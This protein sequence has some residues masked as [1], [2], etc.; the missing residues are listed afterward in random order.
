VLC[1]KKQLAAFIVIICVIFSFY[2]C[3]TAS[4]SS[5][6]SAVSSSLPEKP[7]KA[8]HRFVFMAD[9]RGENDGI[10]KTVLDKI[11]KQIKALSPQPEYILV[12]GDLITGSKDTDT[13]KKQLTAFKSFF[14]SYYPINMLLPAYGNHEDSGSTKEVSHEEIFGEFFNEF[15]PTNALQ[16]YHNTAYYVEKDNIRFFVLNS[17][18]EGQTSR[19]IDEQYDWLKQNLKKGDNKLDIAVLHSPPYPTGGHVGSSLDMYPEKR[20]AFWQLLDNQNALAVF[21]G[22]EHNYTRRIVDS[23]FS[24]LFTR[25]LNQITAGSAGATPIDT[26][27]SPLG[28]I[29]P[30]KPVYHFSVIDVTPDNTTIKTITVDGETL[31][32]F[33]LDNI[34]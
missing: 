31:D 29:V 22:H 7:I 16:G 30:P 8:N 28:V 34:Y 15:A 11:F 13:Y 5:Q 20:D 3:S 26:Y 33:T 21:A 32:E 24:S 14:T 25:P 2:G 12:G 17:Y 6:S 19:I 9:T 27:T 1:L 23:T 18:H 4:I 10:N